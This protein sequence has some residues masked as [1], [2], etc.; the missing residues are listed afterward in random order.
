MVTTNDKVF[1]KNCFTFT[2][3]YQNES[4][5]TQF[6]SFANEMTMEVLTIPVYGNAN[7]GI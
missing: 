6:A 7:V 4:E 3:N 5:Y 1:T 2:R